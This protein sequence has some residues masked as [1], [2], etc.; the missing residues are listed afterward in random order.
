[1]NADPARALALR[2]DPL[3]N[4]GGSGA[5]G[6]ALSGGGDSV[7]LL[8][9]AADWASRHGWRLEAFTFDHGLRPAAAGEVAFCATLCRGL[10]VQHESGR[11][12]E[13]P[14]GGNLSALARGARYAA[15]GDWARRRGLGAV[16]LGHT[17]DDQAETF[18]M[19]LARGS[20]VD[21]LAAM[22]AEMRRD[23]R[24]FLRPLLSCRRE[25]LREFLRSRGQG[26]CEDP[27]NRDTRFDRVRVRSALP[28]LA[29]IGLDVARLVTTAER[30]A[31]ARDALEEGTRQLA[32]RVLTRAGAGTLVLAPGWRAA[33]RDIR[34]RLVAAALCL[35]GA[36]VYRPRLAA[37]VA[38]LEQTG[39]GRVASLHGCLLV[40]GRDGGLQILREPAA[41]APPQPGLEPPWDGRWRL[42]GP[43]LGPGQSVGALTRAGLAEV[44]GWRATGLRGLVLA[45]TPA[46][47]EE[48]RIIAAP[49]AGW[50]RGWQARRLWPATDLPLGT[51][52]D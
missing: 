49:V 47:R 30:M 16:L 43:P 35:Q 24:L 14:A 8:L 11:W 15:L 26:W 32:D 7:A 13:G 23:G 41:T 52:S 1:M 17:A 21:G 38:A 19:R 5:I 22:R 31:H 20:G 48:G 37:L 2:L 3:A 29:G 10:G 42:S 51:I 28:V 44:P 50:G 33:A 25:T 45:S 4:A 6:V 18:L 12:A 27:S 46:I 9:L 40:P 36:Q 34:E 39:R